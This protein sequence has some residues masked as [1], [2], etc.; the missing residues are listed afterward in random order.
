MSPNSQDIDTQPLLSSPARL[1]ISTSV[2]P[3]L[4]SSLHHLSGPSP[5]RAAHHA[6]GAPPSAPGPVASPSLLADTPGRSLLGHF[7]TTAT[8][9][10]LAWP[11]HP[12]GEKLWKH[13]KS[14]WD[15]SCTSTSARKKEKGKSNGTS[16]NL[17]KSQSKRDADDTVLVLIKPDAVNQLGE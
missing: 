12:A 2:Y 17:T 6:T 10:D 1:G 13:Q 4:P 5:H 16:R 9:P 11:H 3:A 14:P 15:A 7:R 8:S